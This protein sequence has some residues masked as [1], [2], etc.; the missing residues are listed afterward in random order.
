MCIIAHEERKKGDEKMNSGIVWLIVIGVA[1]VI[2]LWNSTF[3]VRQKTAAII[4]RFGRFHS[5]RFPGLC[6]K[7]PF[8]D[9]IVKISN[10][11]IQQL[12]VDVETKTHDNVF[13]NTKVSIQYQVIKDQ[14]ADSFYNL[15][16]PV[17]QIESYVF[18]TVRSE[19][20]LLILDDVFSNKDAVAKSIQES[21]SGSMKQF[22]YVIVNSLVTDLQP[23]S[24][25]K[26]AMNKIN[27]TEREK[28]AAKNEA[29]AEKIKMVKKA[30][31]EAESKRLQ[32]QGL[33]NQ[34]QE[35][36]RG[37]RES[38]ETIKETGVSEE[39]VMT[40][41]LV[42]QHYDAVQDVA[43]NSSTNTVMI[44]YSPA[45]IKDVA[46]QIREAMLSVSPGSTLTTL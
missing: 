35:I 37:I 23:E 12:D 42:T 24:M 1:G 18:D 30:E 11:K 40:L 9:R 6:F 14:V 21:L 2:L 5:V 41:L 17:A 22:G 25:V 46:S 3:I 16:N 15:E 43:R 4:E 33:A 31:A 7:M 28:L 8:A 10:L 20:P 38:I 26:A 32:G 13:V 36:A 39:E 44:N 19:I 34:R 27:A 45:G 29:E